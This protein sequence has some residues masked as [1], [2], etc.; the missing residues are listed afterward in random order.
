[1][2]KLLVVVDFQNDF[3]DGTLGFPKA[4]LLEEIIS[5]KISDYR[6]NNHEVV[7]TFDTHA[8]NYLET[9]EGKN[10]PVVHCIK[11]S[12]GWQLYGKVKDAMSE[13]DKTFI[14][15]TFGSDKLF[16]YLRENDFDEIELVGLVSNICVLSN[17]VL[18]KAAKPEANIIV[19][20]KATASF[21]EDLNAKTFDILRGIQ[22]TVL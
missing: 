14:K 4:S 10:L 19:D 1:M 2:K 18:A 12:D 17:A 22:V 6:K 7:F 5:E 11:D 16:D 21:D 9:L 8:E 13:T 20:S 15:Y 3:V